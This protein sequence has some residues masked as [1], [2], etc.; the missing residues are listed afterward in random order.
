[1]QSRLEGASIGIRIVERFGGSAAS[2]QLCT[3]YM[4]VVIGTL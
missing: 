1:M 2:V 3:A 4:T